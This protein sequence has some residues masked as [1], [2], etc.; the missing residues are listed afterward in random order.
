MDIN[1]LLM[2]NVWK[3]LRSI[4]SEPVDAVVDTG[5]VQLEPDNSDVLRTGFDLRL[6]TPTPGNC[7]T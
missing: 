2:L 7:S 1:R 3:R 5:G 4:M 6:L